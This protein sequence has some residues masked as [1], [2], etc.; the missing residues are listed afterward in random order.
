MSLPITAL[1]MI[2]FLKELFILIR[3]NPTLWYGSVQTADLIYMGLS[4][5]SFT[6]SPSDLARGLESSLAR[7]TFLLA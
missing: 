7:H 5:L 6:I 4:P 2:K 3:W 1:Q